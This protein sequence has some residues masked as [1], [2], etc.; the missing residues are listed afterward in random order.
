MEKKWERIERTD[1]K[2]IIGSRENDHLPRF[3]SILRQFVVCK[4]YRHNPTVERCI[5][6]KPINVN[7]EPY[8]VD[9][10]WKA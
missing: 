6:P 1:K 10:P 4:V 8:Q 5:V 3:L 7:V 9:A 2:W